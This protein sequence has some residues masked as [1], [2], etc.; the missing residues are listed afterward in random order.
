MAD[1]IHR[2]I[3]L[4]WGCCAFPIRSRRIGE[5]NGD[6]FKSKLWSAGCGKIQHANPSR[7]RILLSTACFALMPWEDVMF[8][9]VVPGC[10]RG[11]ALRA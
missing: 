10:I 1:E 2:C 9:A 7:R 5:R 4:L 3:S 8:E 6:F 11:S